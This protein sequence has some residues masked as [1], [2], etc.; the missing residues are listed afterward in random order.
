MFE[1]LYGLFKFVSEAVYTYAASEQGHD[2]LVYLANKA[3]ELGIDI[4]FY[5][6][7][8]EGTQ[9]TNDKRASDFA[10]RHPELFKEDGQ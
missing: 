8:P 9:S 1:L 3:E 5:E 4:P 6:P 2:E 7:S 10:A